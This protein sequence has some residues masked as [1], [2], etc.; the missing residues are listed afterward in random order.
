MKEALISAGV[1]AGAK[2]DSWARG[3]ITTDKKIRAATVKSLASEGGANWRFW[4]RAGLRALPTMSQM[5]KFA[6]HGGPAN[7]YSAVYSE[8]IGEEGKCVTCGC[9]KETT[10][11]ALYECPAARG[12]W[13][14]L[15]AGLW[16]EW[17]RA[18]LNWDAVDWKRPGNQQPDWDPLWS[19]LGMVPLDTVPAL[20]D[21]KGHI[22]AFTMVKKAAI[23]HAN[24]AAAVWDARNERQLAWEASIETLAEAKAQAKK[25]VWSHR[26]EE[27]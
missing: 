2:L 9:P 21:K 13:E 20:A 4:A 5:A 7:T 6:A 23:A 14:V 8:H 18:G 27:T 10:Y 1:T 12:M 25:T 17:D 26:G 16:R 3:A 15:D 22:S 24:T 19:L 11:H